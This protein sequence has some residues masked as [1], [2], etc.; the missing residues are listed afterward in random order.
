M[1]KLCFDLMVAVSSCTKKTANRAFKTIQIVQYLNCKKQRPAMEN[2]ARDDCS[3]H[4]PKPPCLIQ[5]LS[6]PFCCYSIPLSPT[7]TPTSLTLG[8][9]GQTNFGW[10]LRVKSIISSII[11]IHADDDLM[12]ENMTCLVEMRANNQTIVQ[13][14]GSCLD[15]LQGPGNYF[16]LM[17]NF[18]AWFLTKQWPKSRME[19]EVVWLRFGHF[20]RLCNVA[21]F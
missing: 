19:E 14:H 3:M 16:G 7:T 15:Y 18:L 5:L 21:F 10:L 12:A 8:V 2:V 17:E 4:P 13:R 1:S 6:A 11:N 9:H 20:W